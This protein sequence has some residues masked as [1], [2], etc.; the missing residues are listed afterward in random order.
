M[1]ESS[2]LLAQFQT[3]LPCP[4]TSQIFS[5]GFMRHTTD[6]HPPPPPSLP[7]SDCGPGRGA[8]GPLSLRLQTRAGVSGRVRG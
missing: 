6:A 8:A 2:N 4:N 7:P 5:M 3:I 1:D